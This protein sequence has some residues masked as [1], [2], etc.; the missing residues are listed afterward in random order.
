MNPYREPALPRVD[1]EPGPRW[2]VTRFRKFF[3]RYVYRYW[4]E[5]VYLDRREARAY[6]AAKRRFVRELAEYEKKKEELRGSLTEDELRRHSIKHAP[7]V[8][9][10]PPRRYYE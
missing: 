4:A 6:E 9:L 2:G 7:L 8:P 5:D 10:P 1:A 3:V